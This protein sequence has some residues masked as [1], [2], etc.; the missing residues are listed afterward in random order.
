M[1]GLDFTSMVGAVS[2]A[3]VIAAI[4]S[5]GI[6]KLGPNFARWAVNKVAGFFGR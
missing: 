1:E 3:A 4:S 5:M 6:V 2:G